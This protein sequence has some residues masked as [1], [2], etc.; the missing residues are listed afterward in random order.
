MRAVFNIVAL[1]GQSPIEPH[2]ATGI[3]DRRIDLG[4]VRTEPPGQ[5]LENLPDQIS[6]RF[7]VG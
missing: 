1:A 7:V 2:N 6:C 5:G 3:V 4:R